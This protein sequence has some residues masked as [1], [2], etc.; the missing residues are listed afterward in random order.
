[1]GG[2]SWDVKILGSNISK[3]IY[4]INMK[5]IEAMQWVVEHLNIKFQANLKFDNFIVI[6]II[7]WYSGLLWLPRSSV[8][9]EFLRN[10]NFKGMN[11][12]IYFYS[13]LYFSREQCKFN[14]YLSI[15]KLRALSH[16][17]KLFVTHAF[18][19]LKLGFFMSV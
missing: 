18:E 1:M 3:T 17:W 9:L 16:R 15:W 19:F 5:L 4:M 2:I 10:I 12:M 8:Y 14:G 7:W 11:R 6:L 13:V